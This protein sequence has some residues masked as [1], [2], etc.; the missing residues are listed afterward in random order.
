[1]SLA[2]QYA[3]RSNSAFCIAASFEAATIEK[4]DRGTESFT[5]TAISEG[6]I[7]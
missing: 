6:Y 5:L 3:I 1:M 7:E 2:A 4:L